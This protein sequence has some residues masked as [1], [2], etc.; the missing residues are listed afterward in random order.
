MNGMNR[1]LPWL[2][3]IVLLTIAT[4]AVA[5]EDFYKGKQIKI[6]SSSATTYADYSRILAKYMPRYIPGQ[7]TI[8]VQIMSGASG[9]T[10]ANYLYFSAPRDGTVLAGTH[11]QIPTEPLLN[12]ESAH[13]DANKFSWIGS[14]TRDT[15]VGYVWHTSPVQSLE[16]TKTRELLVGGQA[17]GSMSVDMSVLAKELFGLKFKIITGYNGATETKLALE[18]GEIN[19]HIG[20]VWSDIKRSNADWLADKKIKVITQFGYKPHP[21]LPDVPLFID[22]AK[23]PEDRQV[24]DLMLARQEMA[25]PYYGPPDVPADRLAILRNAFDATMKDPDYLADMRQNRLISEQP[26]GW[27]E[28]TALVARLQQTPPEI[29]SRFKAAFDKFR[30]GE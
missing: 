2:L 29:V 10:A 17:V 26:M 4:N 27:Q 28:M 23:T 30:A 22:L 25:K 14:M 7:P 12:P 1:S 18:R 3:G 21:D 9:L 24:L 6:I 19:G 16:E 13:F 20:T 15:F 11:G 5:E 8:I